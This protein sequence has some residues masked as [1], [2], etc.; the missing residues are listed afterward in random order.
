[1]SYCTMDELLNDTNLMKQIAAIFFHG[2]FSVA[3]EATASIIL[4][5]SRSLC[6]SEETL[7]QLLQTRF[8]FEHT[9]FYWVIVNRGRSDSGIPPLL[10]HMLRICAKLSREVQKDIIRACRQ[11]LPSDGIVQYIKSKHPAL[12]GT[13]P[14]SFFAREERQP[15]FQ[16]THSKTNESFAVRLAS[17]NLCVPG[18][19]STVTN[20]DIVKQA[21]ETSDKE[22]FWGAHGELP[23]GY[24]NP[25]PYTPLF[26]D[27]PYFPPGYWAALEAH[28]AGLTQGAYF[29]P[30]NRELDEARL[31]SID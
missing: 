24:I 21:E 27:A 3:D 26:C 9:P 12:L 22:D 17:Q 11:I 29:Y 31:N 23:L 1:M 8:F 2:L 4:N 30:G 6:G 19:D 10:V 7:S 13:I 14:K 20:P 5:K 28:Y 18:Y 16:A 15:T 25:V